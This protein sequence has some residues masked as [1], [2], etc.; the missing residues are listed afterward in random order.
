MASTSVV[1]QDSDKSS[2]SQDSRGQIRVREGR[3]F[4]SQ[5]P[6]DCPNLDGRAPKTQTISHT[7][8]VDKNEGM[9]TSAAHSC[10]CAGTHTAWT[11]PC[12]DAAVVWYAMLI[13]V[14]VCIS[15]ENPQL[16][17][18]WALRHGRCKRAPH[19]HF[20]EKKLWNSQHV[21]L[22]SPLE[23]HSAA[24]C[25]ASSNLGGN[26]GKPRDINA[27]FLMFAP[28]LK[29]R[30]RLQLVYMLHSFSKEQPNFSALG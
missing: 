15:R 3:A 23:N 29:K 17:R 10:S 1:F 13:A 21:S 26:R 22:H 6:L 2:F 16:W 8:M 27:P 11:S 14:L 25:A 24:H 20:Q 7:L 18:S 30:K 9:H 4:Y 5:A 12:E 28:F 19:F